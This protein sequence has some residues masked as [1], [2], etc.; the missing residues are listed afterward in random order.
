MKAGYDAQLKSIVLLKNKGNVLPLAKTKT[1]Y[2]P[3]RTVPA[4][5]DWFG[6]GTTERVEYPVN[7]D[8]EKKY[9]NV[10]DDPSKADLAILFVKGPNGGVGYSKEDRQSGGNGYVP[11]SVKFDTHH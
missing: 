2:V 5:R 6:N 11:I 4:A 10:T 9:F 7:M 3:K 8:I 1:V